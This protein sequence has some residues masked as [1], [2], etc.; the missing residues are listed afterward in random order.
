MATKA[1]NYALITCALC[2]YA[3]YNHRVIITFVESALQISSFMQNKPNFR[4]AQMNIS[5]NITREYENKTL[6]E[7]GKNK[8]NTKPI[9][10]QSNPIKA[11][12]MPKQTQ[13]KP[14]TNPIKPNFSLFIF[15]YQLKS[16]FWTFKLV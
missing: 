1:Q 14:N 10:T 16:R 15:G 11:N 8:P 5:D 12:K 3:L 4:N 2:T 6:G 7:R 13:N 9:Q